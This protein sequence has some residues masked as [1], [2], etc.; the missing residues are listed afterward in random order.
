MPIT[1]ATS[2]GEEIP[3]TLTYEATHSVFNLEDSVSPELAS[4]LEEAAAAA[5]EMLRDPTSP[6]WETYRRIEKE[7]QAEPSRLIQ[8]AEASER[9]SHEDLAIR[10]NARD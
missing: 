7:L 9:I 8:A 10:I 3:V 5:D 4:L 2:R 1:S 6:R